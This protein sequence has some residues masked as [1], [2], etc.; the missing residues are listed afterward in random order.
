[1][2]DINGISGTVVGTFW[3]LTPE[4]RERVKRYAGVERLNQ[5]QAAEKLL[6]IA[7]DMVRIPSAT[8]VPDPLQA[9]LFSDEP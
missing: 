8:T 1:M 4:T 9:P 3:R 7:L 5:Q 6:R 2:A